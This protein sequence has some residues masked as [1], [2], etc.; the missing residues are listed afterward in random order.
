MGNSE[1]TTW[2]RYVPP[3]QEGNDDQ[4]RGQDI[5][6]KKDVKTKQQPKANANDNMA[7]YR[8][9]PNAEDS[10]EG[11]QAKPNNTYEKEKKQPKPEKQESS[12]KDK[13]KKDKDNES[14]N[15]NEEET[16][17]TA[18]AKNEGIQRPKMIRGV[19][20]KNYDD[21]PEYDPMANFLEKKDLDKEWSKV[22]DVY[23]DGVGSQVMIRK[24]PRGPR[25]KPKTPAGSEHGT[26]IVAFPKRENSKQF[27]DQN[28]ERINGPVSRPQMKIGN[29]FMMHKKEKYS[30]HG[31]FVLDPVKPNG[32]FIT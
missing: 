5:S 12:K 20:H 32:N 7:K 28:T 13:K 26:E 3:G 22:D 23:I 2:D 25:W 15:E 8:T 17:R 29:D 30:L 31:N 6:N 21:E 27:V 18:S 11:P 19:G 24:K 16:E 1:S 4:Q 14:D 10:K 9:Q